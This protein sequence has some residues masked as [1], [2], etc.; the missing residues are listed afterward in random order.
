MSALDAR[1]PQLVAMAQRLVMRPSTIP[2][3]PPGARSTGRH[4]HQRA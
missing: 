2:G 3:A 1:E 4:R